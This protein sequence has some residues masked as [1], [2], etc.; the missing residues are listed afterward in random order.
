MRIPDE[1]KYEDGQRKLEDTEGFVFCPH[2]NKC[3]I[4]HENQIFTDGA[5]YCLFRKTWKRGDDLLEFRCEGYEQK[6]CRRCQRKNCDDRGR[7]SFCN[8]FRMSGIKHH[9]MYFMGRK[10]IMLDDDPLAMKAEET[11]I[12]HKR[13][14][15]DDQGDGINETG[16]H[17]QDE[18]GNAKLGTVQ[19][20]YSDKKGKVHFPFE[21]TAG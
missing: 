21:E 10:R 19:V 18:E 12:E 6:S 4:T 5:F 20:S 14:I 9:G 13:K 17:K 8:R 2:C 15:L 11:Y 7:C 1:G 16:E 3:T